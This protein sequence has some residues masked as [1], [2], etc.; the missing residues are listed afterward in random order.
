MVAF[1]LDDEN[2]YPHVR[3]EHMRLYA[4]QGCDKKTCLLSSAKDRRIVISNNAYTIPQLLKSDDFRNDRLLTSYT[5]KTHRFRSHRHWS[6]TILIYK[7]DANKKHAYKF[8]EPEKWPP[9]ASF[10]VPKPPKMFTWACG[11]PRNLSPAERQFEHK[12]REKNIE[13]MQ[14]KFKSHYGKEDKWPTAVSIKIHHPMKRECHILW[15]SGQESPTVGQLIKLVDEHR[16]LVL[17]SLARK[18][19]PKS[20]E[21]FFLTRE[22][23]N[24]G[25]KEEKKEDMFSNLKDNWHMIDCQMVCCAAGEF[26]CKNVSKDGDSKEKDKAKLEN[27]TP[28]EKTRKA[29]PYMFYQILLDD[30]NI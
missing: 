16:K 26:N 24:P 29:W 30:Q 23:R 18:I 27:D 15:L 21:I 1:L 5:K 12:Q 11:F 4:H 6:F 7:E 9:I 3:K 2:K 13:K 25:V 22:T 8:K 14:M 28:L 17:K 19:D 10:E 20:S